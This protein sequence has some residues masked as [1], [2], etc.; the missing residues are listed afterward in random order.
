[1]TDL[2]HLDNRKKVFVNPDTG[3]T[4]FITERERFMKFRE[5]ADFIAGLTGG[6]YSPG[7]FDPD[8]LLWSKSGR[9]VNIDYRLARSIMRNLQKEGEK[10]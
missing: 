9:H 10:G 1:M 6:E 5:T 7:G 8:I 4:D 2:K 3:G